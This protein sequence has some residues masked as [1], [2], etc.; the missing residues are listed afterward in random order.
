LPSTGTGSKS[1]V[2]GARLSLAPS[3]LTRTPFSGGADRDRF[4]EVG[5]LAGAPPTSRPGD[6]GGHLVGDQVQLRP[7]PRAAGVVLV[8]LEGDPESLKL[9]VIADYGPLGELDIPHNLLRLHGA[10]RGKALH[11]WIEELLA[12]A[13]EPVKTFGELAAKFG[14]NG[15]RWSAP[16]SPKPGWSSSPATSGT[17][18]GGV[19]SA[20]P[21]FLF[22]D[23]KRRSTASAG[24]STCSRRSST[25][26]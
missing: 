13:P 24:R 20:Y 17:T 19:V 1:L 25:P 6:P 16:T 12:D 2:T 3:R 8:P 5:L 4:E 9:D 10:T 7:Y 23:P 18:D 14:P 11:K 15:C 26:R 22:D 21:V